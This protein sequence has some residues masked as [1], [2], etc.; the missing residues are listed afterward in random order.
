MIAMLRLPFV[1]RCVAWAFQSGDAKQKL[2]IAEDKSPLIHVFDARSGSNEAIA[3]VKV[4]TGRQAGGRVG[5][6]VSR[7]AGGRVA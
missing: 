1:P 3:T 7:Q 4:R 5:R 6:Q 2:M